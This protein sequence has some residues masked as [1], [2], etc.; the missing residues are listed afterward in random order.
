MQDWKEEVKKALAEFQ[1]LLRP[2][3]K[4]II[5]ETLGSSLL[6]MLS[7]PYSF[8]SA[9]FTQHL[10]VDPILLIFLIFLPSTGTGYENPHRLDVLVPYFDLLESLGFSHK[11]IRTDYKFESL[12][13]AEELARF[14]FGN[15][16]AE[17]VVKNKWDI[18][19]ECTGLWWL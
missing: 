13:E 14:F 19:P 18:L 4:M 12:N 6:R 3:G 8:L 1:R 7:S 10:F 5:I 15:E 11:S 16:L 9:L 17:K 2:G